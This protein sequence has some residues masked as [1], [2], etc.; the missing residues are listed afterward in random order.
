[1]NNDTIFVKRYRKLNYF[2]F[3]HSWIIINEDIH[4]NQEIKNV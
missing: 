4:L 3:Q 1:M 2:M